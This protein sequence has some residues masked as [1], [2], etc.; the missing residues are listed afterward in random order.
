MNLKALIKP[1]EA[2]QRSVKIKIKVY[3]LSWSGI[4]LLSVK[5]Q[6]SSPL[7]IDV[8]IYMRNE[9]SQIITTAE[10]RE[11]QYRL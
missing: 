2:P 3:F 10:T 6:A 7:I 8:N 9:K 1:F 4:G 5:S 11:F